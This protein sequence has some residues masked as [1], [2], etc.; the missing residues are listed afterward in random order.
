[1]KPEERPGP[2]RKIVVTDEG[3]DPAVIEAIDRRP[4]KEPAARC[5]DEPAPEFVPGSD[6]G[7]VR[8][9]VYHF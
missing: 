5:N 7:G 9:Y 6:A 8:K 3:I 1:M 2:G 4:L